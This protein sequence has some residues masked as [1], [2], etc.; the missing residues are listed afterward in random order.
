[1][2]AAV[3]MGTVGLALLASTASAQ[4]VTYD[5]AKGTDFSRLKTYAWSE[6]T[7]VRDQINHQRIVSAIETQLAA[8]GLTK[9]PAGTKPDVFVAYH[10]SFDRDLQI[11]AFSTDMGGWRF[12]MGSRSG[13]ARVQEVVTGTLVIDVVQAD[14]DSMIWRGMAAKDIDVNANGEKREKNIAKAIEK[15]FKHFPPAK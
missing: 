2:R 9:A 7:P 4:K 13:S 5:Y 10:A 12:G 15:I 1:M 14:T 8:K 3:L 6:G 11:N